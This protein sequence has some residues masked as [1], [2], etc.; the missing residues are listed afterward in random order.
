M[1][2]DCHKKNDVLLARWKQL[3]VKSEV[4]STCLIDK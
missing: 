1:K 2:H 3:A 4:H